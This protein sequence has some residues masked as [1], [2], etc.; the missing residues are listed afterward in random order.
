MPAACFG[1]A[2]RM[3]HPTD[4][5]SLE[6]DCEEEAVRGGGPGGQHRNKRYTGLRLL[7]RPTGLVVRVTERRSQAQNREVAYARLAARIEEAQQVRRRRRPTRP[8][9]GS[10]ERRLK[11]KRINSD[12]KSGRRWREDG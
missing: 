4:R 11:K 6:R 10:N 8:T 1:Y 9:R 12:R 3:R 5:A 2:F 7:H